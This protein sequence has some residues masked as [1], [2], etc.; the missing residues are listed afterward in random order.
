MGKHYMPRRANPKGIRSVIPKK[1][2]IQA[3]GMD[4][5]RVRDTIASVNRGR[6]ALA[7]RMRGITFWG[8]YANKAKLKDHTMIQTLYGMRDQIDKL[9]DGVEKIVAL[10]KLFK[11]CHKL[12]E[13][14]N[15]A[16]VELQS[17]LQAQLDLRQR[18]VEHAD[19]M[20]AAGG[21][22]ELTPAELEAMAG[23]FKGL[24]WENPQPD[25]TDVRMDEPAA[26]RVA[27]TVIPYSPEHKPKTT[28]MGPMK[29]SDENDV[30][31][32]GSDDDG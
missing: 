4:E 15:Q 28:G 11:M 25:V 7:L 12:T 31:N 10:E 3:A 5:G 1:A 29:L 32:S 13:E 27:E 16:S 23:E 19:K 30:T 26:S 2:S 21:G 9:P 24:A 22:M 6:L 17:V 18:K 20:R 14:A 8:Q